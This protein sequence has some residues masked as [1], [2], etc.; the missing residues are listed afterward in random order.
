MVIELI[1][2]VGAGKSRIL[3]IF[4]EE[5]GAQVLQVDLIAKK[6]Q[7][8]GGPAYQWLVRHF[9]P[10]ILSESGELDRE[11]MAQRIFSDPEAMA[12]VNGAIHPMVWQEV[13]RCIQTFRTADSGTEE[14]YLLVETAIPYENLDDIYDEIWYVYTLRETRIQRLM[15]NRGYSR[16]KALS[17]MAN[18]PAEEAY[19]A[20]ADRILDNNQSLDEIRDEIRKALEGRRR[21]KG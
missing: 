16:Q 10:E 11:R 13:K 6:L 15:E 4:R 9:G 7:E 19:K 17:I 21:E 2:G 5:Y 12:Q 14:R 8:K 1:G 18:Q 3:E 20:M